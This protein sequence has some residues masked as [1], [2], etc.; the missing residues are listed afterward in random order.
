MPVSSDHSTFDDLVES[1]GQ[2]E[3]GVLD[4]LSLDGED[5]RDLA[6]GKVTHLERGVEERPGVDLPVIPLLHLHEQIPLLA[7]VFSMRTLHLVVPDLSVL[8]DGHEPTEVDVLDDTLEVE[9]LGGCSTEG[10]TV[11]IVRRHRVEVEYLLPARLVDEA[12]ADDLPCDDDALGFSETLEPLDGQL[13]QSLGSGVAADVDCRD[14]VPIGLSVDLVTADQT[15]AGVD[16]CRLADDRR[17]DGSS[18]CHAVDAF[19]CPEVAESVHEGIPVDDTD[20][21]TRSC[22]GPPP[23]DL[24]VERFV[25]DGPTTLLQNRE[26]DVVSIYPPKGGSTDDAG[27]IDGAALVAR[28]EVHFLLA[29][30]VA[31]NEFDGELVTMTHDGVRAVGQ[32]RSTVDRNLDLATGEVVILAG[33]LGHVTPM[34]LV[35][36][37]C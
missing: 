19:G 10:F 1:G 21:G 17:V 7:G 13:L 14:V 12:G 18:V 22:V 25:S 3:L 27:S 31:L 36:D 5:R 8:V 6:G 28:A 24:D 15:M 11:D 20:G 35:L 26:S 30:G 4:R 23:H 33:L 34:R 9:D 29:P 37:D 32:S 16:L 2:L